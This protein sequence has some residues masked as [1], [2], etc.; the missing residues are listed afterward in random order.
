[1]KFIC[2][3]WRRKEAGM[4]KENTKAEIYL[5]GGCFWGVEKYLGSIF[6]VIA[7]DA[8]YANGTTKNPSYR[9]VCSGNTGFAEAVHVVYDPEL[10]SLEFLLELYY[11]V[12]DPVSYNRQGN[13]TGTQYRTGIYYTDELDKPVILQSLQK[14]SFNYPKPIAIECEPLTS[15]YLAEEYHQEYLDKNPSG[16]CHIGKTHF[17]SAA[18]ARPENVSET[19]KDS[20]KYFTKPDQEELKKQLTELQYQVTQNRGTEPAFQNEYWNNTKVGIYV[21]IT[22]GEPLF[23]SS[24]QFESGCGWPSFT[25]PIRADVLK[26]QTDDSYGMKRTEVRSKTGDAHLGH[27]FPDGPASEGGL[28]YCINS[29]A[30]RFIPKD[31]MEAEGYGNIKCW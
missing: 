3:L 18:N 17:E 5:A 2:R 30:L 7:T 21:D 26:E 22:T 12:I 25:R 28:R 14:L 11:Q 27:V 16:Y 29:A 10:V 8:G 9:E 23:I 13:D 6:G 24:D 1:M 15:Y 20:G 19:S 4:M 31:Q